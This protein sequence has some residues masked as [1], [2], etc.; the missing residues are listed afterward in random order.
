MDINYML[1]R[2]GMSVEDADQIKE[3]CEDKGITVKQL[4]H[5]FLCDLIDNRYS[6]GSDERMLISS[7][8]LRSW[9]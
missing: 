9:L 2:L 4:I 5:Q 8:F 7:W 1:E 6:S 3:R